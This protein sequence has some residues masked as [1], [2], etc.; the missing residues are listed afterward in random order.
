MKFISTPNKVW[1]NEDVEF[2]VHCAD[3]G[4]VWFHHNLKKKLTKDVALSVLISLKDFFT[5]VKS[6]FMVDKIYSWCPDKKVEKW[7]IWC[8]CL[9]SGTID[10]DGVT[11]NIVEYH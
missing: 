6:V 2:F 3:D 8:G 5:Q 7:A 4:S 9:P 10:V 11:Y 1:E